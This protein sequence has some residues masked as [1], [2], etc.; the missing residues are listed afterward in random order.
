M[1]SLELLLSNYVAYDPQRVYSLGDY[2]I[3]YHDSYETVCRYECIKN[4]TTGIFKSNDWKTIE[5]VRTGFL[6]PKPLKATYLGICAENIVYS[7]RK[8]PDKFVP[9]LPIKTDL[10][11]D[12][13]S[14]F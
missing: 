7:T 11:F 6:S 10:L 12:N 8:N 2:I 9:S 14:F 4:N 3:A 5:C 1:S 13:I